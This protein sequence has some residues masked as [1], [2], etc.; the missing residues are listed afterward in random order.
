MDWEITPQGRFLGS[1]PMGGSR[2]DTGL[3]IFKQKRASLK[4][5]NLP[6]R[7]IYI[8]I[9]FKRSYVERRGYSFCQL[10]E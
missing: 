5:K 4:S 9:Y 8:Y 10:D 2:A 7:A 3:L 6:E 1:A